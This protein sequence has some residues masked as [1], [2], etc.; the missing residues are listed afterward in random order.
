AVLSYSRRLFVKAFMRAAGRLGRRI[1]GAFRHFGGVPRTVLGDNARALV[2]DS[3]RRPARCA[4]IL[5][6]SSSAATGMSSRAPAGRPQPLP[7]PPSPQYD[8]TSP[9]AC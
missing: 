4:S 5:P 3:E 8:G 7:F 9:W 2:L 1:A 6:I